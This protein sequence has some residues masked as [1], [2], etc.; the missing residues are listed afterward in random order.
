MYSHKTIALPT[1]PMAEG[2]LLPL[3]HTTTFPSNMHNIAFSCK[4][5]QYFNNYNKEKL[6]I[7]ISEVIRIG[8][9]ARVDKSMPILVSEIGHSEFTIH[10][11]IIYLTKIVR[12]NLAKR[13]TPT[14]HDEPQPT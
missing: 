9:N 13:E 14:N 6:R 11:L 8:N 10:T 12:H 2:A 7:I 3:S 5:D 4:Q 1:R